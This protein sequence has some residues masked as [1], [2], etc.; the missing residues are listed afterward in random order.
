MRLEKKFCK[1]NKIIGANSVSST[2]FE[3]KSPKLWNNEMPNLY[4]LVL[5]LKDETGNL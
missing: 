4:T 2:T 1:N 3:G 5:T